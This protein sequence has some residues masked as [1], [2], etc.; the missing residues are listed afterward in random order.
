[1]LGAPSLL[2]AKL[3][4]PNLTAAGERAVIGAGRWAA[5]RAERVDI[6]RHKPINILAVYDRHGQGGSYALENV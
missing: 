1:M 5:C 6:N 4:E 2:E 3:S